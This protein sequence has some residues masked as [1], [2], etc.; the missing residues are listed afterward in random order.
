MK[1]L[2]TEFGVVVMT[3]SLQPLKLQ[4]T[5]VLLAFSFHMHLKLD[6]LTFQVDRV[7]LLVKPA[8]VEAFCNSAQ[9]AEQTTG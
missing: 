8:N 3:T 9:I 2:T 7:S 6:A 1:D 4:Y 5:Q